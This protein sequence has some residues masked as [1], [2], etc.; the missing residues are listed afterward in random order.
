MSTQDVDDPA[1]LVDRAGHLAPPPG[2]RDVG[3]VHLL[4]VTEGVPAR[5]G[6]L[7]EQRCEPLDPAVDGGVVDLDAAFDQESSEVAVG[8]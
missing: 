5:P 4:A 8:L 6:G 2:H 3:F 1:E 7:S